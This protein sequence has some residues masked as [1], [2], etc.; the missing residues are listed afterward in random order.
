MPT[1]RRALAAVAVGGTIYA[2]G[3]YDGAELTANEAY[4]PVSDTWSAKAPMPSARGGLAAAA[5]GG[6]IYAIGG[7]RYGG[8]YCTNEAYDASSNS[9]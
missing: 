7:R 8:H 5:V 3:G 4:D 1:A 2:I 9:C 6:T